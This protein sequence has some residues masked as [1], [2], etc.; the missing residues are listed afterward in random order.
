MSNT[1]N[2]ALLTAAA[3]MGSALAAPALPSSAVAETAVK[4]ALA[5][6]K[7]ATTAAK[8]A[9]S[10]AAARQQAIQ[11]AE[12]A[13]QAN[14]K[15]VVAAAR[16]TG[17][18]AVVR[19]TAYNSTPGQTDSSPFITATGTRVRFGTVALSRDLLKKFPYGTRIKIEDLS[20][21]YNSVLAGRV[22]IVEDTMSPRKSNTVD[23]WMPS[24]GQ[25]LQWGNRQIRITALK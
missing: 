15:P 1:T 14:A 24:R 10:A 23:V 20:G 21:R 5:N 13:A 18:S 3:L 2:R 11:Q 16:A 6:E 4:A 8:P 12:R 7:P 25:A 9:A 17:A 19:S 22:F